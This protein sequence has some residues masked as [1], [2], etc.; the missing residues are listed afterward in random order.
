MSRVDQAVIIAAGESKRFWPL[1]DNHTHKSQIHLMGKSLIL[2]TVEGLIESGIRDIIVVRSPHQK[3]EDLEGKV[4]FVVQGK[5]LGSGN[6]L[7]QAKELITESFIVL[8]PNKI[9]SK[10]IVKQMRLVGTDPTRPV[11]VGAET[12]NP[13]DF[14]M[15]RFEGDKIV[16]LVEKP[17]KGKEPST[18][19]AIGAYLLQPDFFAYYEKLSTNHE[20]DFIDALNVYMKDK[21]VAVVKLEKDVPT[22]KYPWDMFSL[23]DIVLGENEQYIAKSATVH[24]TAVITGSVYI[25]EGCEIGAYNVLRGPLNLEADV[26]TGAFMEIKH[27]IVQEGTHFHSGYL[28][29]SLVGKHCRFGAGFVSA[30]KRFDRG[31]VRSIVSGEKL[32]T[33]LEALGCIVG[34]NAKFGIHAGTMP[35]VLVSPDSVI[36]PGDHVFENV[37]LDAFTREKV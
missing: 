30:N 2:R 11:L 35:G 27:S 9:N 16:E 29:D 21:Q 31:S 33:G 22:L 6:A 28:G 25:G 24:E 3:Y 15:M 8:W 23:M 34:S 12:D 17:E 20:A 5:P 13:A 7:L 37:Q 32:D 26:K 1:A 19:K 4:R 18:T 36:R 10:E 14:A